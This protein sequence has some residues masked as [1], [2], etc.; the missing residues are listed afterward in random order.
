MAEMSEGAKKEEKEVKVTS[1]KASLAQEVA[2]M[3]EKQLELF[4]KKTHQD[5]I[6]AAYKAAEKLGI[7]PWV[8]I[9]AAGWGNFT[10]DRGAMYK[11][12]H[13]ADIETLNDEQKGALMGVF[14]MMSGWEKIKKVK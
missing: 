2:K 6:N 14:G 4:H 3:K 11:G 1:E 8:L 13:I 12:D 9:R 7:A 10:E 5:M